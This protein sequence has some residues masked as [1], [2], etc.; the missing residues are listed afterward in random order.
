MFPKSHLPLQSQVPRKRGFSSLSPWASLSAAFQFLEVVGHFL[1]WEFYLLF[2]PLGGHFHWQFLAGS[3]ESYP[4]SHL[5][6]AVSRPLCLK[7]SSYP[8]PVQKCNVHHH[9]SQHAIYFLSFRKPKLCLLGPGLCLPLTFKLHELV[10]DYTY[11][12]HHGSPSA[13]LAL[14]INWLLTAYL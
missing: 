7:S 3:L 10:E 11:L 8:M 5:L 13:I 2:P 1:P 4:L 12:I 9:L 14:G 6:R